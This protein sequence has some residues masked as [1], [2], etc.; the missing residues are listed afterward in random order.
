MARSSSCVCYVA[1]NDHVNVK[2]AHTPRGPL[3]TAELLNVLPL[4]NGLALDAIRRASFHRRR[5]SPGSKETGVRGRSPR[6]KIW[7]LPYT[8][9]RVLTFLYSE[10][11]FCSDAKMRSKSPRSPQ[12]A[13]PSGTPKK[14]GGPGG[15]APGKFLRF[16]TTQ[17]AKNQQ[18]LTPP[19]EG[20]GR[21]KLAG[22]L[23]G[24]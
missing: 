9:M 12:L 19:L 6:K 3:A 11:G 24:P 18:F 22:Y 4:Q 20:I 1:H 2:G 14:R 8:K 17:N 5:N 15:E 21:P 10:I 7:V 13:Q 23:P 16:C